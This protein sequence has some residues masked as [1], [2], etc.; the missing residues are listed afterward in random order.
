MSRADCKP[1]A[2]SFDFAEL[3]RSVLIP[4]GVDDSSLRTDGPFA[5]RDLDDC[6]ALIAEYVDPVARF[7]VVA[8]MGHL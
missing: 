1:Y 6:L 3:R 7:G 2:D 4:A 8:Y 5:Y